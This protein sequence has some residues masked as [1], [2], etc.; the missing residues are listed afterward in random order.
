MTK[1]RGLRDDRAAYRTA[2]PISIGV[3]WIGAGVILRWVWPWTTT[4][5]VYV[6]AVLISLGLVWLVAGI[7][8]L[9]DDIDRAARALTERDRV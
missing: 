6:A 8:R 4:A 5:S 3:L 2:L 9:V 7:Y 1:N